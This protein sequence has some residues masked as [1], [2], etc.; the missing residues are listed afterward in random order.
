MI[1]LLPHPPLYPAGGLIQTTPDSPLW[2]QLAFTRAHQAL[3]RQSAPCCPGS[4]QPN[5]GKNTKTDTLDS[6]LRSFSASGFSIFSANQS[7]L[8]KGNLT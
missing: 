8:F 7:K 1:S 2:T 5:F 3:W 6:F 4:S